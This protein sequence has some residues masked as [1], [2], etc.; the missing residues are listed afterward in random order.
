MDGELKGY[1]Y[2]DGLIAPVEVD[3]NIDQASEAVGI[4]SAPVASETDGLF[5]LGYWTTASDTFVHT[6]RLVEVGG[7]FTWLPDGPATQLPNAIAACTLTDTGVTG[8]SGAIKDTAKLKRDGFEAVIT[9]SETGAISAISNEFGLQRL[10]VSDGI[11]IKM[12]E[13]PTAIAAIGKPLEGGYGGGLIIAAGDVG[14][15]TKA[16]FI[17]ADNLTGMSASDE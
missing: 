4:C 13:V 6:G 12:P 8:S 11:S 5:R 3:L 15:D 16:V 10:L 2:G 7:E 14:G 9:L 1:V 17:A